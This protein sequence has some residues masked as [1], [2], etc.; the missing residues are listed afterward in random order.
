MEGTFVFV[1]YYFYLV[2]KLFFFPSQIVVLFEAVYRDFS[3]GN[4]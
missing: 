1:K 4:T 3:L 2:S